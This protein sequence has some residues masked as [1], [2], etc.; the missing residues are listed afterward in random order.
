MA[1]DNS[2]DTIDQGPAWGWGWLTEAAKVAK[3]AYD[4][5][6]KPALQSMEN[7]ASQYGTLYCLSNSLLL[8]VVRLD[9]RLKRRYEVC[10]RRELA[11]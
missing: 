3:N 10:P 11:F 5:N 2:D 9:W 4:S 6:V 1:D 7:T 8:L